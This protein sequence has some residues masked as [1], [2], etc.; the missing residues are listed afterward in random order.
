MTDALLI[1]PFSQ[2]EIADAIRQALSMDKPERIRRFEALMVRIEASNVT[3]WRQDF[4]DSLTAMAPAG[5]RA[6]A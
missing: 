6:E 4:V 2:E 1:N 3:H 5:A